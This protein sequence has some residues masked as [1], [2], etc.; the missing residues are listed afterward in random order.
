MRGRLHERSTPR[1]TFVPL[2]AAAKNPNPNSSNCGSS[3]DGNKNGKPAAQQQQQQQQQQ[4][5][6]IIDT[7]R[8]SL[9]QQKQ[10]VA[11]LKGLSSSSGGSGGGSGG[12]SSGDSDGSDSDGGASGK[13][14]YSSRP[15]L[16]RKFRR[17]KA[18]PEQR[19]AQRLRDEQERARDKA[20]K[21][22]TFALRNIYGTKSAS[23]N[24][25]V[26][27]VD[28]YNVGFAWA[29]T[30]ND[31]LTPAERARRDTA[32]QSLDGIRQ[33]LLLDLCEFSQVAKVKVVVAFDAMMNRYA[34]GLQAAEVAGVKVVYCGDR[35]AD[36]F[37][38]SEARRLTS[39]KGGGGG[40]DGN[41]DVPPCRVVVVSSDREVQMFS[42]SCGFIS[43]E[44]LLKEMRRA[45]RA[46]DAAYSVKA[47]ADVR[48][49]RGFRA[50]LRPE[51]A[52]GLRALR[53]R[54]LEEQQEE[55]RL[56]REQRQREREEKER[57]KQEEEEAAA[58]RE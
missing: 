5:R 25:P 52:G 22:T 11:T 54:L 58:R 18:T 40:V 55:L 24:P 56:L 6:R 36:A 43:S 4:P 45:A 37:L 21:G 19:E 49:G 48:A 16:A 29:K 35:D 42:G 41:R 31:D 23:S 27:L 57:A 7:S 26:L 53:A 38:M 34:R 32:A 44:L 30:K 46:A 12:G 10:L 14:N 13:S 33:A 20:T 47:A 3:G 1:S 28:G 2:A 39:G 9:K 17:P 50:R 15:Q 51:Q 8:M